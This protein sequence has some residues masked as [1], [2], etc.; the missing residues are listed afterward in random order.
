MRVE[1][2]W[3]WNEDSHK[4]HPATHLTDIDFGKEA[5]VSIE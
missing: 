2:G 4:S 3:S 5:V 1:G